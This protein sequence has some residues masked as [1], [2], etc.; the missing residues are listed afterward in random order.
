VIDAQTIGLAL[1]ILVQTSGLSFWLGK[2]TVKV[3]NNCVSIDKLANKSRADVSDLNARIDATRKSSSDHFVSKTRCEG[4]SKELHTFIENA[5]E[6]RDI[7]DE[8]Y[9]KEAAATRVSLDKL[10][11]KVDTMQECLH[12]MQ[13]NKEC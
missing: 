11:E 10:C 4:T 3:G 9:R 1:A 12:K 6:R 8:Q 2:L 13:N 5:I 7:V